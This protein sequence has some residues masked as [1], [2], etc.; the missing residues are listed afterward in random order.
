[1]APFACALGAV[2]ISR[3][4]P[5]SCV[6]HEFEAQGE[7]QPPGLSTP[8]GQGRISLHL[9]QHRGFV[10]FRAFRPI[11]HCYWTTGRNLL[12]ALTRPDVDWLS[13]F[14]PAPTAVEQ[15]LPSVESSPG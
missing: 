12:Q 11:I 2:S 1:M 8:D 9:Q 14:W 15:M 3:T 10:R 13:H 4:G 6:A 5:L 7:A